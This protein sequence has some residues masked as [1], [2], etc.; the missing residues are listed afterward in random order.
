MLTISWFYET[1]PHILHEWP[2]MI[3]AGSFFIVTWIIKASALMW[4]GYARFSKSLWVTLISNILSLG[5]LF[6]IF[7]FNIRYTPELSYFFLITAGSM[8]FIDFVITSLFTGKGSWVGGILGILLAD[9]LI[10]I[11]TTLFFAFR[12]YI[13][14]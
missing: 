5:G 11:S 2:F 4:S 13:L 1:F 3:L 10:I 8:F 6:A 7:F 9:A 14:A 12:F